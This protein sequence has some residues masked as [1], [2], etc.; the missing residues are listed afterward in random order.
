MIAAADGKPRP[1]G[2]IGEIWCANPSVMK[3]YLNQPEETAA[4]FTGRWFHTGDLGYLDDENYLHIV[5]RL[6]DVIISGGVNI[7]PAEIEN[8]L[9]LHP[10]IFDCAVVGV[11]D[12][13]WGQAVKAFVVPRQGASIDL[14]EVQQ[15]CRQRLA[16][17][18]T[19][20][21]LEV[22]AEIPKNIAGKTIKSA[23][24]A[25]RRTEHAV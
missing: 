21:H 24:R 15:H 22:I 9:L 1:A 16:D 20:R 11:D 4:A 25:Q 8:V 5:G 10:T 23:L 2:E 12:A 13:K 18:K 7:Y 17:Y 14:A 19:P 3:C 6:K